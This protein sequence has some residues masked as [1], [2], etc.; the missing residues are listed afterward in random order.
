MVQTAMFLLPD[1]DMKTLRR[2][3]SA[4]A[5][6]RVPRGDQGGSC[7]AIWVRDEAAVAP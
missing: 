1:T 7:A 6:A 3:S 2:L 5:R 4:P